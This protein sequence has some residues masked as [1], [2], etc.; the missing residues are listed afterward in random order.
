[1]GPIGTIYRY[2]FVIYAA[3]LSFPAVPFGHGS[4]FFAAA[5]L[6]QQWQRLARDSRPLP[7]RQMTARVWQICHT[8]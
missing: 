3:L 1:M 7:R 2:R 6:L 8:L 5:F 4:R